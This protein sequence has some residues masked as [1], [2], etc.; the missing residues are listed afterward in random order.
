M[1]RFGLGFRPAPQALRAAED[2]RASARDPDHW[3][4]GASE[5][6]APRILSLW[7]A[8]SQLMRPQQCVCLAVKYLFDGEH[9]TNVHE[10]LQ[11]VY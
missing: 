10:I 3:P 8:F 5:V 4:L 11:V 2:R 9:C 7:V 6:A 1:K